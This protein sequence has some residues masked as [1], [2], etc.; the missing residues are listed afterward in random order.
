MTDIMTPTW[1]WMSVFFFFGAVFW[2]VAV[3]AIIFGGKDVIDIVVTENA[4]IK[5]REK[6]QAATE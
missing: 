3:W 4:K 1:F 5:A 6:A 2:G